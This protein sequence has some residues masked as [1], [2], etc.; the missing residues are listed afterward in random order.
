MG[1]VKKLVK[2]RKMRT[3]PTRPDDFIWKLRNHV[4]EKPSGKG[5][6]GDGSARVF[7]IADLPGF[8]DSAIWDALLA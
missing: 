3:A 6:G 1:S 5:S 4:V 7:L 8:G 2:Y